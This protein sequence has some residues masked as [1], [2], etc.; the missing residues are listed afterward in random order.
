[1]PIY[2]FRCGACEKDSEVL[3]RS[4]DWKGTHCPHCNSTNLS[5]K[6]SVFAAGGES[7][8]ELPPCTGNPAGCGRC[9]YN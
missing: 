4:T 2:E 7:A 1:M 5:K 8:A 3:V 6:L 9:A